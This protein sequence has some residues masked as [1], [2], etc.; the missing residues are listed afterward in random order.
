MGSTPYLL[1]GCPI[2]INK[3]MA[4]VETINSVKLLSADQAL[5][6]LWLSVNDADVAT[7]L[8]KWL[9]YDLTGSA[10]TLRQL[11]P[12]QLTLFL[13]KLPDLLLAIYCQQQED[14]KGERP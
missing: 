7:E 2:L 9:D 1:A 8:H 6:K 14:Q 4:K 12:E 10:S 13:D 11:T 5:E 3:G